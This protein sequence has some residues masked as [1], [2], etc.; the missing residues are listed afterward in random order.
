MDRDEVRDAVERILP[1][2]PRVLT[3]PRPSEYR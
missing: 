1:F 2:F 3:A